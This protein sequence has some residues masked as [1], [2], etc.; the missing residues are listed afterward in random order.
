M[1]KLSLS[2]K[3][4]EVVQEPV[5]GTIL[6]WWSKIKSD[7]WYSR[8]SRIFRAYVLD[9]PDRWWYSRPCTKKIRNPGRRPGQLAM[10][11]SIV[12]YLDSINTLWGLMIFFYINLHSEK[13]RTHLWHK[14]SFWGLRTHLWHKPTFRGLRHTFEINLHSEDL[15]THRLFKPTMRGRPHNEGMDK[16]KY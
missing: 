2:V 5:K 10:S 15:I 8:P 13:F 11:F 9:A 1:N 4:F 6:F 7:T 12:I 14:P 3:Y 16:R